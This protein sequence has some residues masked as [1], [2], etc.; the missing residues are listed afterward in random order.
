[1][2][3]AY[4]LKKNEDIKSLIS[5]K[6]SVGNRFFTIYYYKCEGIQIAVS[7]SKKLGKAYLRNYLKRV[8]KEILRNQLDDLCNIKML[9][10]IKAPSIDLTFEEKRKELIKLINKIKG[11]KNEKRKN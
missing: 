11:G 4:I 9:I 8:V 2:N 3:K 5:K 1:M 10:V 6:Q 7:V